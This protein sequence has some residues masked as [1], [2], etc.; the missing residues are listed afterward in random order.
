ML[1]TLNLRL[2]QFLMGL[3]ESYA[4]SN[5]Q[6]M[7]MSPTPN[8][9][10][11]YTMIISEESRRSLTISS[12]TVDNQENTTLFSSGNNGA[13]NP[14]NIALFTS[15]GGPNSMNK[16][17]T[18]KKTSYCNYCN[19]KGHTRE[20]CYKL[21]GYPSDFKS[22]KKYNL[23]GNF[24]K[25]SQGMH[26]WSTVKASNL[27]STGGNFWGT[28][29]NFAGSTSANGATSHSQNQS[30]SVGVPHF[31]PELYSQILQLLGKGSENNEATMAAGMDNNVTDVTDEAVRFIK[32]IVDSGATNHMDL[33]S[34]KVKEIGKED[35]RLYV[36]TSN[37]RLQAVDS[38]GKDT[39]TSL[40]VNTIKEK[41][42]HGD[43]WGPYRV[44]THDG[45]RFWEECVLIAVYLINM[46]PTS[47]LKDK[48]KTLFKLLHG[49][50]PSLDHL[51]VFGCLGYVT[52]LRKEDKF[53]PR[54]VPAIF[55]G[56]SITQK[57]YK[58]YTT[59]SRNFL[60]S[61]DVVFK[62]EVFPF[63]YLDTPV[64]SLFL[65]LDLSTLSSSNYRQDIP[66]PATSSAYPTITTNE[67]TIIPSDI[68]VSSD[69]SS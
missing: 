19:Y 40:V 51:R 11:V 64:T 31:T 32:S 46:L 65:V 69:R 17:R 12:H 68:H 18:R 67:E 66:N 29:T 15:K 44:P 2:L 24:A 10:K 34:G 8:I 49:K 60:V 13:Y 37:S 59:Y 52:D 35:S 9:N 25:D 47:A 50:P 39:S 30:S 48:S 28:I 23:A 5:N 41:D 4:Q 16:F 42:V 61:R 27:G 14:K 33:F 38:S 3:N 22:K 53:S 45:K 43:V 54:A 26:T 55:L 62:E 20:T 21:N 56:Y 63:Q 57:G 36:L 58:I 6:I 1:N 7:M